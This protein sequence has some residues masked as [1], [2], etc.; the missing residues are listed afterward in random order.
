MIS[1]HFCAVKKALSFFLI[2]LISAPIVVKVSLVAKYI[3]EYQHYAYELC[4]NVDNQ[5]MNCN[6]T[7]HLAKE[8]KQAENSDQK[9]NL[10][11]TEIYEPVF[12]HHVETEKMKELHVIE[13]INHVYLQTAYISPYLGKIVPP[14]RA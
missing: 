7:C 2:V 11:V 6:G 12:F 14:P 13:M 1:S 9:P 4:E 10:P 3:L 5:T 8:L